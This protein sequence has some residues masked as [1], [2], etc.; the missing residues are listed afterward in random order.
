MEK[1]ERSKIDKA[2][3]RCN[4]C[5]IE[6]DMAKLRREKEW[7]EEAAEK[8]R[9]KAKPNEMPK[10]TLTMTVNKEDE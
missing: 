4:V 6:R 7:E 5:V 9:K 3:C 8:M 2:M 1:C 10:S